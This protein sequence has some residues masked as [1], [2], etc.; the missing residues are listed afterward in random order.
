MQWNR[1][2]C[3]YNS[4]YQP[5]LWQHRASV[6]PASAINILYQV[7]TTDSKPEVKLDKDYVTHSQQVA[8]P[9]EDKNVYAA[10]GL[11]KQ[12]TVF[13]W[14]IMDLSNTRTDALS[15]QLQ[16]IKT[17]LQY[18]KKNGDDNQNDNTQKQS[19]VIQ[20]KE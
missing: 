11:A 12:S 8:F 9:T 1:K 16:D 14:H 2:C 13:V 18:T 6:A 5:L 4:V 7:E 3:L 15:K 20:H 19:T 17:S 10:I